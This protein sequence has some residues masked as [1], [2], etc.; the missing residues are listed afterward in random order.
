MFA[1]SNRS[2][3][4]FI[5]LFG[6]WGNPHLEARTSVCTKCRENRR[7]LNPAESGKY[8]ISKIFLRH[9][10]VRYSLFDIQSTLLLGWLTEF[11]PQSSFDPSRCRLQPLAVDSLPGYAG[12][13]HSSSLTV[14]VFSPD[15]AFSQLFI[16]LLEVPKH[17][18]AGC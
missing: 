13:A 15:H 17:S 5:V 3:R 9:S 11:I 2:L 7:M 1:F 14:L 16:V 8:R 10:A 18:A 4:F 12:C 6:N